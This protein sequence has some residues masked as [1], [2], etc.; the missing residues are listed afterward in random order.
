M[1]MSRKLTAEL[2]GTFLLVFVGIG[3]IVLSPNLGL[4]GTALAFGLALAAA[5]YA[6]GSISGGHFNPAVTLGF[7]VAKR[8]EGRDAL[9]YM[10]AQLAGAIVA[11]TAIFGI[12]HGIDG[13][14]PTNGFAAN[15]FG[16]HS[17][18]HFAAKSA[19][20]CEGL[21]TLVFVL[22]VL[23][24]TTQRF[25]GEFAPL[26]TGIAFA[27]IYL[28]AL[29]VTGGGANP[30]RSTAAALYQD[31]WAL[32]ELWAFW[33]LPLVGGALAGLIQRWFAET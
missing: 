3:T 12:A 9:P 22:V 5:G 29:P 26:V 6:F 33:L 8:F 17:P 1:S 11:A 25:S 19:L 14:D 10:A 4:A 20:L 28:V 27:A 31:G 16:E 13:F 21:T 32:Y 23:G 30:A 18:A 2:L 15:G 7:V 24:A